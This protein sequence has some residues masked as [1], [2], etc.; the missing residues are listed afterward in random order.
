MHPSE[1]LEMPSLPA[2]DADDRISEKCEANWRDMLEKMHTYLK[3]GRGDKIKQL[4]ILEKIGAIEAAIKTGKRS[5][6]QK[7]VVGCTRTSRGHSVKWR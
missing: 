1:Y 7:R 3:D 5:E 4:N 6:F 2:P